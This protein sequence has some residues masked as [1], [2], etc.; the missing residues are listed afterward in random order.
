MSS[1]CHPRL[2][3]LR[4]NSTACSRAMNVG[5]SGIYHKFC[6]FLS[7]TNFLHISN[8]CA[9]SAASSCRTNGFTSSAMS[10]ASLFLTAQN[11]KYAVISGVGCFI[12]SVYA[13][14]VAMSIFSLSNFVRR[15]EIIRVPI[16]V[17]EKDCSFRK[18]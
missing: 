14:Q 3:L 10:R 13:A 5:H 9:S 11:A 17:L 18:P 1:K 16:S 12:S 4:N 7:R 2:L 6:V 8:R 15:K